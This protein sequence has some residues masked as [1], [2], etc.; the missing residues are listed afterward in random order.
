MI[1]IPVY[2]FLIDSAFPNANLFLIVVN[3]IELISF[4][5]GVFSV[6]RITFQSQSLSSSAKLTYEI[7]MQKHLLKRMSQ[8]MQY[9][10]TIELYELQLMHE[11]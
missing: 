7:L 9:V 11:I 4:I 8:L 1:L 5:V 10:L 6:G 2:I 3:V